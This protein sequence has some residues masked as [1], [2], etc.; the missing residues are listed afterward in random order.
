V[1]FNERKEWQYDMAQYGLADTQTALK[2]HAEYINKMSPRPYPKFYEIDRRSERYDDLW[3]VPLDDRTKFSRVID[4]LPVIV[5]A[6]RPD[7]RLTRV[8]I[9]PQQ[10]YKV[11]MSNLGL[12]AANYFPTR[13]DIMYYNGYRNMII[14]VVIEPTSMWMQTNVWLGLL[15]ETTIP[16]DGDARPLVSPNEPAPSERIQTRPLPEA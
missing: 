6:E 4:E 1:T 3:H 2:I 16:A 8:G 14:N 7:W 15:V 5:Q 11:W 10:K 9:V 13:G 12:Q